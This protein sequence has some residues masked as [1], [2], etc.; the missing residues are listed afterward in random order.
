[1]TALAGTISSDGHSH[2]HGST[3]EAPAGQDQAPAEQDK[4]AEAPAEPAEDGHTSHSH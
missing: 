3:A 1:M 4:P 2:D